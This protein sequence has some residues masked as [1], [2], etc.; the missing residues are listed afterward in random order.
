[1]FRASPES[2]FH[3][4]HSLWVGVCQRICQAINRFIHILNALMYFGKK[5]F[6]L[7]QSVLRQPV[8]SMAKGAERSGA[9]FSLNRRT[10]HKG[11]N[12]NGQFT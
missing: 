3:F 5:P 4:G 9:Y 6:L 8:A 7:A 12:A 2:F 10:N 11:A 1:M